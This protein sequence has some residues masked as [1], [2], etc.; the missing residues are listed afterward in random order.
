MARSKMPPRPP[1][2]ALR[3]RMVGIGK[4][5]SM[6]LWM[7]PALVCIGLSFSLFPMRLKL[8][9]LYSRESPCPRPSLPPDPKRRA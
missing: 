2:E 4:L 9:M 1:Q 8:Y 6:P 7:I 5:Q 3:L